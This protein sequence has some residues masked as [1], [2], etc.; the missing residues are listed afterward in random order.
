[1]VSISG[2][3]CS[4]SYIDAP[5]ACTWESI[6]PGSTVLPPRSTR[7]VPEPGQL[8]DV[9]VRAHRND[10]PVADRHR[11][12]DPELRVD[13]HDLAVVEDMA[14]RRP[15]LV[16]R[17]ATTIATTRWNTGNGSSSHPLGSAHHAASTRTDRSRRD[18][19]SSGTAPASFRRRRQGLQP[20]FSSRSAT[21]RGWRLRKSRRTCWPTSLQRSHPT[22]SGFLSVNEAA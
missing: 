21:Q 6:R 16:P 20:S 2:T 14:R 15:G 10:P 13:G 8:H 18:V 12:D 17:A 3:G 22:D 7:S 1:M 19:L 4:N 11:L 5:G 9:G